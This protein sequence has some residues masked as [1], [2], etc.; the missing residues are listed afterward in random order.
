M[1]KMYWVHAI[2]PVHIGSGEGAGLIDLPILREKTTNW[3]Y[4]PGS[5]IKGV[6]SDHFAASKKEQREGDSPE[7]SLRRAA[8]GVGG[9]DHAN[10]GSLVFTDCRLVAMPVRSLYGT[11]A[12]VTSNMAL[13]RLERDLKESGLTGIP[14][15]GAPPGDGMAQ[16]FQG[17][18]VADGGKVYLADFDFTAKLVEPGNK[19]ASFLSKQIF[20]AKD[21][22]WQVEFQRRLVIL[23]DNVFNFLTEMGTEVNAHIRIDPVTGVVDK[24][25]LWY[26]ECIP[27]EAVLAGMV[28]CDRIFVPGTIDKTALMNTFCSGERTLQIGGKATVGKGR[29]RCVFGT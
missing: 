10:S 21:D 19:W 6:L 14:E 22:P 7:A 2:S 9:D 29:V 16:F 15:A 17:S 5:S 27:A 3:P 13:R 11:F 26:E 4:L 24:G 25:A 8:F 1:K 23:P 12:F 28:W 18:V 20:P